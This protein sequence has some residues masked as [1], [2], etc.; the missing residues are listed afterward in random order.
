MHNEHIQQIQHLQ[1]KVDSE[2]SRNFRFFYHSDKKR[3]GRVLI[4]P[5]RGRP[6]PSL[7]FPFTLLCPPRPEDLESLS[8]ASPCPLSGNLN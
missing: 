7:L 6:I 3:L 5:R 2:A 1:K 8:A 4:T